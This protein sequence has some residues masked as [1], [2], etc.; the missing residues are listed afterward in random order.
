MQWGKE[1]TFGELLLRH[2]Q[3]TGLTQ[4]ELAEA[5]GMS[6]RAIGDIERGRARGPQRRS[7]D[8]LADALRLADRARAEFLAAAR[9]GRRRAP[10]GP[11]KP[12][13]S[14]ELIGRDTEL[15]ELRAFAELVARGTEEVPVAAISG[16]PGVGKTSLL[17]TAAHALA[18]LFPDGRFFL[19]LRGMDEP[20]T[21]ARALDRLLRLLG[22]P[23]TEIRG[24]LAERAWLYRSLLDG[25]RVLL[26]LDNVPA[27]DAVRMLLPGTARCLVLVA[28][29]R[30]L[31][32]LTG[33]HHRV[34]NVLRTADAVTL[35]AR[36][37]GARRV[38]GEPG[39]AAEV[40]RLC[41]NLPLALR[42]AGHRLAVSP[43][44][45]LKGLATM[46][47]DERRLSLLSAGHLQVRTA[48]ALSYR[49]L[50]ERTR[51]VFRHLSVVP[52]A[53]FTP[54]LAAV[55]AGIEPDDAGRALTALA[56]ASLVRRDG[57]RYE[58]HGLLRAFAVE[59]FRE[60]ESP[61]ARRAAADRTNAWLV[62]TATRAGLLFDVWQRAEPCGEPASVPLRT[63]AEAEAWL[64][65]EAGNW[66]PAIR[67]AAHARWH[68]D[69][70]AVA[71]ALHWFSYVRV[72]PHPWPELFG[73]GRAPA[74]AAH[75]PAEEV[76]LRD[77]L[78][79]ALAHRTGHGRGALPT[80]ELALELTG[81]IGD[82]PEEAWAKC[83]QVANLL[84]L[85]VPEA[86]RP[87][88]EPAVVVSAR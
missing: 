68:H 30:A 60:E 38:D 29:R 47:A 64:D 85:G 53:D 5:S 86:L 15:A 14:G 65:A 82:R 6:V 45:T 1:A 18:D 66:I 7:V 87:D 34:L 63:C 33:G 17:T 28:G 16:L 25:K 62:H 67:Y 56:E 22:V 12:D 49:Q 50:G 59:R 9:R 35:L 24:S 54:A 52:G 10:A 19:D 72:R 40:A 70:I 78:C 57:D 48:F 26:A 74:R 21:P 61:S 80:R 83:H 37:A 32:E 71:R 39:A 20:L 84:R 4:E 58:L 46:L 41:G 2:R 36:I 81:A 55:A 43:Q 75:T 44:W 13:P 73:L 79:W 76:A 42:L 11:P 3:A 69:V 27:A 77:L 88:R 51:L 31:T 23:E 8:A